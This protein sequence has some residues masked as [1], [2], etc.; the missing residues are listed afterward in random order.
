MADTTSM[1]NA[2]DAIASRLQSERKD[3]LDLSLRNPLLNYR[4]RTR[5]LEVVGTSSAAVFR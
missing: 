3:L 1:S 5:G 2:E 4:P